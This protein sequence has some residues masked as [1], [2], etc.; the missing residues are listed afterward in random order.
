MPCENYIC[1]KRW[2]HI[3]FNRVVRLP[4]EK[5]KVLADGEFCADCFTPP[6]ENNKK[7]GRCMMIT[8]AAIN[9]D[10]GNAYKRS[11]EALN[12][13]YRAAIM[14]DRE[15]ELALFRNRFANIDL[16]VPEEIGD[17]P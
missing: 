4:C 3:Y 5:Q 16:V 9:K 7:H 1:E 12:G 13:M 14:A 8:A 15:R 2:G 10:H 6:K 17:E 11:V